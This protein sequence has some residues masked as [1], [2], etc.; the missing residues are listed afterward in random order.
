MDPLT[1]ISLASNVVQFV[2]FAGKI[3]SKSYEFHKSTT[4]ALREH[5]D[6]ELVAVDLKRRTE[7][8]KKCPGPADSDL[9]KLS[10]DCYGVAEELLQALQRV[11]IKGTSTRWKS[12]R[13]A[14]RSV[15]S[16]EKILEL[17]RRLNRFRDQI[18]LVVCVQLRFLMLLYALQLEWY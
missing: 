16:K 3:I 5:D 15:W 4:G 7:R 2:D 9:V 10:G 18:N 14:L 8:L 12:L 11:T 17:E 13:K 6:V 1:A